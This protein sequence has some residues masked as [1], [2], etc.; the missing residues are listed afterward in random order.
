MHYFLIDKFI[1]PRENAYGIQLVINISR[2]VGAILQIGAC[3]LT[4]NH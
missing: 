3:A 4:T 2:F 1:L